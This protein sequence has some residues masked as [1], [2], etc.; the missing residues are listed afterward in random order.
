M[1]TLYIRETGETLVFR[2]FKTKYKRVFERSTGKIFLIP[3]PEKPVVR[4]I[5]FAPIKPNPRQPKWL[6]LA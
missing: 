2:Q 3:I 4:K 1:R 6:E 5:K